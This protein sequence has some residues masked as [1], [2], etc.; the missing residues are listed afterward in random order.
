MSLHKIGVKILKAKIAI[1]SNRAQLMP[2]LPFPVEVK[3]LLTD[4]RDVERIPFSSASDGLI[5]IENQSGGN[6]DCSLADDRIILR[7]PFLRLSR[8]AADLRYSFWGN[9]GLLYRFALRLLEKKYGIYSFHACAL[10]EEKKNLLYVIIGGAGSGKTV[11]LLSGL[12]R[13][14]RLFSTETVHFKV[15]GEETSWFMGSLI[16]NIRWGTLR[17][18]FPRFLPEKS[19]LRVRAEW[20]HKVALDLSAFRAKKVKLV[21]PAVIIIIP[22]IEEGRGKFDRTWIKNKRQ[23]AKALFDNISEK[24]GETVLLYDRWPVSG[25]DSAPLAL[26]RI[27]AVAQLMEDKALK[28]VAY[29][30]AGPASCWGDWL[31]K[32]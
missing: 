32:K 8:Q 7:G 9:Q 18:D 17:H 2:E 15:Q 1:Q 5:S 11:C 29:V 26:A 30:L 19:P 10:F 6:P 23:A 3:S 20:Q 16:D 22:R 31:G 21:N 28:G 4:F 25:L 12:E 14:L 27:K 24:L 13:G